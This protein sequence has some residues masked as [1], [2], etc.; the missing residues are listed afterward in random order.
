[1]RKDKKDKTEKTSN[2]R[3]ITVFIKKFYNYLGRT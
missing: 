1:M 3:C 2:E